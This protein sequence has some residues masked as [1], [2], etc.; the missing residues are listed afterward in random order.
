M[1]VFDIVYG[2]FVRVDLEVCDFC[3]AV[4]KAGGFRVTHTC[5]FSCQIAA[6]ACAAGQAEIGDGGV[7]WLQARVQLLGQSDC[8][9]TFMEVCNR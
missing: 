8:L 3:V 2:F 4:G 1:Y 5:V 7:W 6:G 9:A